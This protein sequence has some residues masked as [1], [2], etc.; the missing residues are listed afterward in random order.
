M[1]LLRFC[2]RVNRHSGN[3]DTRLGHYFLRGVVPGGWMDRLDA[4]GRPATDFMPASTL[5]HLL[6]AVAE[7]DRP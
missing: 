4:E 1:E 6:G 7:L 3:A 2:E 5:Y